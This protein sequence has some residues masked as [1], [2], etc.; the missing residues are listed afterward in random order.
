M[1]RW[2]RTSPTAMRGVFRMSIPM[3]MSERREYAER[4][5]IMHTDLSN[6]ELGRMCGMSGQTI[7][8][9]RTRL[10]DNGKI[11]RLQMIWSTEGKHCPLHIRSNGR[12]RKGKMEKPCQEEKL[13]WMG[14]TPNKKIITLIPVDCWICH[15]EMPTG[16][17]VGGIHSGDDDCCY[18]ICHTCWAMREDQIDKASRGLAHYP[19]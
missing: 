2:T 12:S 5:L 11:D 15:T 13:A 7:Q 9:I 3:S 1:W 6:R 4:M 17:I 14:Y 16:V 8:V 18:P 10:E 19:T